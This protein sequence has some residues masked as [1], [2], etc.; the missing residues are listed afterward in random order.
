MSTETTSYAH[1]PAAL[2]TTAAA[3]AFV[4]TVT[5]NSIPAEALRIGTR[6]LLDGLGLFVAGSEE[7]MVQLLV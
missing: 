5:F 2:K 4:E 3:A 7:H 6:C 1:N